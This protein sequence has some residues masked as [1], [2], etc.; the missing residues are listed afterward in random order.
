MFKIFSTFLKDAATRF[1]RIARSLRGQIKPGD[2]H[3]DAWMVAAEIAEKR[4]WEIDFANPSDQD[5]VMNRVFWNVKNQRD[6]RLA[7]AYSINDDQ[8]GRTPWADRLPALASTSPLEILLDREASAITDSALEASYSQAAA[9]TIAL[10]NFKSDRPTLCAHLLISGNA[11]D[12]RMNRA[13]E[14]VR[15]Q[16]SLFNGYQVIASDFTPLAGQLR[17][18]MM[19]SHLEPEQAELF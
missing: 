3:A 10:V 1:N 11:L 2:L 13:F 18:V 8:E 12:H 16:E 15:R 4:G 5:L 6:W 9:Y 17:A 19:V 7:S 14:V